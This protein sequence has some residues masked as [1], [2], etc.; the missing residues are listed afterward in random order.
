[1]TD[2]SSLSL[3]TACIGSIEFLGRTVA[4]V[5]AVIHPARPFLDDAAVFLQEGLLELVAE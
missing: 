2:G 3:E 5:P 1:M 4:F